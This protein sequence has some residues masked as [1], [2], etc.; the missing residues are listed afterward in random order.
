V[1]AHYNTDGSLDKARMLAHQSWLVR[2]GVTGFLVPGS[3]GDAWEMSVDEKL[4]F[5]STCREIASTIRITLHW[6]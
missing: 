1:L 6:V 2:N 4:G 5:L 3:T